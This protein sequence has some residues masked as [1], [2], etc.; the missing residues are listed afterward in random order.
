[1]DRTVDRHGIAVSALQ[2]ADLNLRPGFVFPEF[3]LKP[4][5]LLYFD[6]LNLAANLKNLTTTLVALAD[7][8]CAGPEFCAGDLG[9]AIEVA[10][11]VA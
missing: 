10:R 3:Y 8:R 9:K 5:G 2:A 11:A 6:S 7:E 4:P 1:M